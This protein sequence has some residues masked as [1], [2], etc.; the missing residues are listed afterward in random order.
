MSK[1]Q[2]KSHASSGRAGTAFAG[3]GT[4]AFGTSQASIL[5][6]VQEAPDYSTISEPNIVVAFKNLSKKDETTKAKALEDLQAYVVSLEVDIEDGFLDVW[7]SPMAP[8]PYRNEL[9]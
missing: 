2:F 8:F 7:V 4:S 1:R 9:C 6:Y 3:F 5:S